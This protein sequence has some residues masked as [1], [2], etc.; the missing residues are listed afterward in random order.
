MLF[1]VIFALP[2]FITFLLMPSLISFAIKRKLFD[3][4]MDDKLKIHKIPIP[5]LGGIGILIGFIVPFLFLLRSSEDTQRL[6]GVLIGGILIVI[7]GVWDDMKNVSPFIRIGWQLLV[8]LLAICLGIRIGT[9]PAYYMAVPLTVVYIL[10]SINSLNLIDGLDG[11]AV[12]TISI[13][14]I[15]FSI[16]FY[17]Q[18]EYVNLIISLAV[19]GSVLGF[20]PYNFNPAKIFLGDNGSTFLGY[21]IAIVAINACEKPYDLKSFFASLILIGLPIIDTGVAI[22]RRFLKRRP[23]FGGDRSHIYDWLVSRGFS[24][25]KTAL[26]CYLMQALLVL[27]GLVFFRLVG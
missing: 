14:M 21:M 9:F 4:P 22:L 7:L 1:G 2:F 17:F 3:D 12:G 13:S 5:Y 23:I 11:L 25:K 18:R 19:L 8:A 6:W 10:G 24:I 20:L 15:G 27:G 16:L 26:I